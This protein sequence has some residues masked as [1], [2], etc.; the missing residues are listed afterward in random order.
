MWSSE[1]WKNSVLTGKCITETYS[2]YCQTPKMEIFAKKG[3]GF[4]PLTLFC[5]M[6][7]LRTFTRYWIH[8]FIFKSSRLFPLQ[9][10]EKQIFITLLLVAINNKLFLKRF[11]CVPILTYD[12]CLASRQSYFVLVWLT[13]AIPFS[14]NPSLRL[15]DKINLHNFFFIIYMI[16]LGEVTVY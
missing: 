2:K 12:I 14:T 9:N 1:D 13:S 6:F 11:W 10:Q 7:H 4:H 15:T 5:K 8:N 3:N 16:N